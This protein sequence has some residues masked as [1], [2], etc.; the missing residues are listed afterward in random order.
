MKKYWILVYVHHGI[1]QE[2]EIFFDENSAIRRRKTFL[3]NFNADYDEIEVFEK[4]FD[5]QS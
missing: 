5:T 1:I 3:K 4:T 2:P